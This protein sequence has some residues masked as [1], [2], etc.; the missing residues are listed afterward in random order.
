LSFAC[1]RFTN[2]ISCASAAC[3]LHA[4]PADLTVPH[5]WHETADAADG[6]GHIPNAQTLSDAAQ[7]DGQAQA[8][9]NCEHHY[10]LAPGSDAPEM[11]SA[12]A[13]CGAA[14]ALGG[15]ETRT[16]TEYGHDVPECSPAD[17]EPAAMNAVSQISASK[18]RRSAPRN[19]VDTSD[20]KQDSPFGDVEVADKENDSSSLSL[21]GSDTQSRSQGLKEEQQ[22]KA[23][24]AAAAQVLTVDFE[25]PQLPLCCLVTTVVSASNDE[26]LATF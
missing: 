20:P 16:P 7:D 2:V 21:T 13:D 18:R 9:G 25:N 22:G 19:V 15:S 24:A 12:A 5:T 26:L 11:L 1:D 3:A 14:R 10:A 6:L 23:A 4:L 17:D 8:A